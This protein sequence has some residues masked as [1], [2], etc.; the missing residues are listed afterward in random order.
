V[1]RE[2]AAATDS[3]I[4]SDGSAPGAPRVAMNDEIVP[5]RV[6]AL[7]R[8]T[9]R[10]TTAATRA[11]KLSSMATER[12][13]VTA[14][15]PMDGVN[16]GCRRFSGTGGSAAETADTLPGSGGA[17]S[18]PVAVVALAP[19][20]SDVGIE[21]VT[22]RDSHMAADD[23][24]VSNG[25]AATEDAALMVAERARIRASRIRWFT[26]VR[27]SRR[28]EDTDEHGVR[29]SEDDGSSQYERTRRGAKR[30]HASA[31]GGGYGDA[32]LSGASGRRRRNPDAGSDGD[33]IL[34]DAVDLSRPNRPKA[35]RFPEIRG[36]RAWAS[37]GLPSVA[38]AALA[39]R[40]LGIQLPRRLPAQAAAATVQDRPEEDE[41]EE[42][43]PSAR[44]GTSPARGGDAPPVTGAGGGRTTLV[45]AGGC[46]GRSHSASVLTISF[47]PEWSAAV[48]A[49]PKIALRAAIRHSVRERVRH[50][51][52]RPAFVDAVYPGNKDS[53][54][55][56]RNAVERTF[57]CSAKQAMWLMTQRL[58]AKLIRRRRDVETPPPSLPSLAPLPETPDGAG[59]QATMPPCPGTQ[60]AISTATKARVRSRG[61]QNTV[62]WP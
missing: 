18:H 14:A 17:G 22:L 23:E 40:E 1:L 28:A 49:E 36:P 60:T 5:V 39:V 53:S 9:K 54:I 29:P 33:L 38:G 56:Y 58:P 41:E 15:A 2:V 10:A 11:T 57:G 26:E 25:D 8:R 48:T 55:L 6:A 32:E 46:S 51:M 12:A 13:L 52:S 34:P 21:M 30:S 24:T 27:A 43:P 59:S 35:S 3:A 16:A 20:N 42:A 44:A 61:C 7:A 50:Y 45:L 47:P 62:F 31:A 4:H 19:V 37:V